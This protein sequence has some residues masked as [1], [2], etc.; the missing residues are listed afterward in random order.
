MLL[1]VCIKQQQK[2]KHFIF[3]KKVICNESL[4]QT[5]MYINLVTLKTEYLDRN[6]HKINTLHWLKLIKAPQ[7]VFVKEL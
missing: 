7:F 4:W 1:N 2:K 5:S 3:N 6:A